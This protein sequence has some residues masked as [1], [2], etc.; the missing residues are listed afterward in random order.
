MNPKRIAVSLPAKT[1]TGEKILSNQRCRIILSAVI[2]FT[3]NLLYAMYH[4]ALGIMNRSLWFTS[5]CA[6]YGILATMRFSAVLCERNHHVLPTDD[7]E[8]FVMKFSGI[9]IVVLSLVLAIVSYIS[10]TQNIATKHEKITMITIATYTFYKITMTI[11]KVVKQHGN[12]SPLFRAIRNIGYAEVAASILTLQRSML[13]SFGSMDDG[14]IYTMNAIT[15][16]ATCL[17]VLIL[18]ISMIITSIRKEPKS[19]Q[20]QNL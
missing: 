11:V 12:P 7:T 4:C 1:K 20:N 5:M 19:W 15:G 3:C 13:V 17:F 18:G 6:F 10:L 9:L 14:Q 2:A 8:I 16:A